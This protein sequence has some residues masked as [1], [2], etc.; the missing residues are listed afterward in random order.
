MQIP[1][2]LLSLALSLPRFKV[3]LERTDVCF[4]SATKSKCKKCS[5][6]VCLPGGKL[7]LTKSWK[8]VNPG[9]ARR[10]EIENAFEFED[11]T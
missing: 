4:Y 6:Y 7:V 5:R 10:F 11:F 8:N 2:R 1:S 9:L 3:S